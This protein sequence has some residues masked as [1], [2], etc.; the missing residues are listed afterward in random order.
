VFWP[1]GPPPLSF[2]T[3]FSPPG[4]P[5]GVPALAGAANPE[6]IK[7]FSPAVGPIQEGLPWAAPCKHQ[8]PARVES[9][10]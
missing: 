7:S 10:S 2:R 3:A 4:P 6:G 5:H 1:S 9:V 8:Y